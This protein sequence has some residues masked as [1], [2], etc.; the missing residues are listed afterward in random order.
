MYS[1]FHVV[2]CEKLTDADQRLNK[3]KPDVVLL[4]TSYHELAVLEFCHSIQTS[5]KGS[6]LPVVI[7]GNDKRS[8]N[9]IEA[10]RAGASDFVQRPI[11]PTALF[12]RLIARIGK[13]M[14]RNPEIET[15]KKDI[16]RLR[17]DSEAYTVHL[18]GRLLILSRKEFELLRILHSK[19]GRVFSRE[20][21]FEKVWRKDPD[22]SD[23]TI[24]VHI[25]RLRKKLGNGFI[26]T[27]KGIGYRFMG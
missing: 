20:E 17:I 4:D 22:E 25:L 15:G 7:I 13:S 9:E 10:F 1:D 19:P 8:I 21:I 5:G 26:G 18:D 6:A 27:Q 3:E 2:N 11:D 14:P 16:E 24:D 23:R 12:L